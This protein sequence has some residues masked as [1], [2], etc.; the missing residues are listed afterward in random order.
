MSWSKEEVAAIKSKKKISVE[1][2]LRDKRL[3]IVIF[4][5]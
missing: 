2:D 5:L 3:G 4:I 1:D